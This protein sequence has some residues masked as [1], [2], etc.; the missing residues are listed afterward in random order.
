[1]SVRFLPERSVVPRPPADES[2]TE[3]F[4][5]LVFEL[6]LAVTHSTPPDSN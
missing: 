2:T 3:M 1:M 6:C 4:S 5:V